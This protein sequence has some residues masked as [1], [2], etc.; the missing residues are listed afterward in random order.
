M[1]QMQRCVQEIAAPKTTV[2]HSLRGHA[3]SKVESRQSISM[4]ARSLSAPISGGSGPCMGLFSSGNVMAPS[5]RSL[6]HAS[7]PMQGRMAALSF[8]PPPP[9]PPHHDTTHL[10]KG[11][12]ATDGL[13]SDGVLASAGSGGAAGGPLSLDGDGEDEESS[14]LPYFT[15]ARKRPPDPLTNIPGA[16]SATI[17]RMLRE[18]ERHQGAIT[19][20]ESK[21]IW[22]RSEAM[23]KDGSLPRLQVGKLGLTPSFLDHV[24]RELEINE[25]IRLDVQKTAREIHG[26]SAEFLEFAFPM[27]LDCVSIKSKGHSIT[28]YRDKK[29]MQGPGPLSSGEQGEGES[30]SQWLDEDEVNQGRRAAEALVAVNV[31]GA[32]ARRMS[33]RL[34]G[35]RKSKRDAKEPIVSEH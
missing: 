25:I 32:G 23:A 7:A 34:K 8:S 17:Y 12:L 16:T 33:L 5:L 26:L 30:A 10:E 1:K 4:I 20:E 18:T 22:Y 11:A 28:L 14:V 15:T 6:S 35:S 19:S 29:A 31:D 27:M 2:S 21:R 13:L 9:P 24:G 3:S